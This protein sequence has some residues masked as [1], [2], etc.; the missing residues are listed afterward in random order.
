MWP[1]TTLQ[2]WWAD[3]QSNLAAELGWSAG[4]D[5]YDSIP[6]RMRTMPTSLDEA[7]EQG[8]YYLGLGARRA[9]YEGLKNA[10]VYLLEAK[11]ALEQQ[12]AHG[13]ESWACTLAGWG[14]QTGSAPA[15]YDFVIERIRLAA[16]PPE[17]TTKLLAFAQGAKRSLWWRRATPWIIGGVLL[18]G[19]YWFS[20]RN[21]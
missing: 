3:D 10:Q 18:G 20:R 6:V 9:D 16:L 15:V 11:A 13:T 5:V 4:P 7:Y 1:V 8:I 2:N 17:D 14:C 12:R 21:R 19:G